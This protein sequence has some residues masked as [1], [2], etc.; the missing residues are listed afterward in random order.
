MLFLYSHA[1]SQ[2]SS[3]F[4]FSALLQGCRQGG[5]GLGGLKSPQIFE[6]N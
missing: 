5:G 3:R 4:S 2:N 1:T 6:I